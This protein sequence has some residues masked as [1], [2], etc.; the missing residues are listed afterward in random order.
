[1]LFGAEPF[2][3]TEDVL[4]RACSSRL[5]RRPNPDLSVHRIAAASC[6]RPA[7]GLGRALRPSAGDPLSEARC[8]QRRV[9]KTV[10]AGCA[11]PLGIIR[12]SG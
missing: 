1:M 3:K 2:E 5:V 8:K 9:R 4:R 6:A 11:R 12:G 10:H 7:A